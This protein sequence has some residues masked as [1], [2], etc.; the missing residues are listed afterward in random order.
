M[1]ILPQEFIRAKR[2]GETLDPD[3]IKAFIAGFDDGS[4]TEGQVAAFAMAVFFRGMARDETVALT[5]A[6][7]DSGETLDWSDLDRPVVDKHSTGGIGDNVSLMLAPI[8]AACGAAV[9]MISGR[10]LGHTGGTLDKMESIPGYSV[11]PDNATFRRTVREVGCAI[12]G[13][14]GQL[15]PADK[16]FYGV[17]DVTATVE[18]IPLITA[19]ILSKKLAGGL[20]GL[21]LDVKCGSGAFMASEADARALATSLVEVANGAG[22]K[23]TA[24]I[25]RMDQALASAAGNAVEVRNAVRFLT[26]EHRDAALEEVT[27]ALAAE[28]LVLAGLAP[29]LTA[30]E[31]KARTALD[32]GRA[33]EIFGRMVAALGGPA[34]FVERMDAYLPKAP[35]IRPIAAT[36][37]GTVT[38]VDARQLGL[39]IVGLGGGRTRPQDAVDH[40]VG[41][42]ELA[43][44]G[45]VLGE[46]DPI[47]MVHARDGAAAEAAV[48]A[49]YSFGDAEPDG[50]RPAVIDRIG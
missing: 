26:G 44:I 35:V 45:T 3:A 34:D 13:Q 17:R 8:V 5:E 32:D 14:T 39:C 36:R 1:A 23:T 43:A 37:Q 2:D 33:A 11:T 40:S 41:L 49:A 47:A 6:M 19:S 50:S 21:V 22:L 12:I 15:A 7:R 38:A 16:R 9:P 30:A 48:R 20:E 31:A 46:G 25:T 42:T 10:G 28:M 4:V 27:L 18:S 29:D 24:L